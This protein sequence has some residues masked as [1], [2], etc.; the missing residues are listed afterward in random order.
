[1][2]AI[3]GFLRGIIFLDA[4]VIISVKSLTREFISISLPFEESSIKSNWSLTSLELNMSSNSLLKS[5]FHLNIIG[6]DISSKSGFLGQG[7]FDR[8]VAF[9]AND[10]KE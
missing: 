1:M 2:V 9:I 7:R 6:C 8:R 3:I 10:K 4:L 5:S